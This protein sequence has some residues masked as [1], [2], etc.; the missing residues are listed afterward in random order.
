MTA[1]YIEAFGSGGPDDDAVGARVWAAFQR[2]AAVE[3]TAEAARDREPGALL[4]VLLAP[5]AGPWG[6]GVR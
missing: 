6:G 4:A 3:E 1:P 2:C 5:L